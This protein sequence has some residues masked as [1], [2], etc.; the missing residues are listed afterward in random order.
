MAI[1]FLGR[2]FSHAASTHKKRRTQSREHILRTHTKIRHIL[3]D[4]RAK[5]TPILKDTQEGNT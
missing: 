4:T 3:K 2:T 1:G 5:M